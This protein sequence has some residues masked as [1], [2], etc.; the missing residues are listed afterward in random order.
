MSDKRVTLIV[1]DLHVGG[2][3]A[4]PGDD[5]VFHKG[6]FAQLLR[7]QAATPEGRSG[8][9]E[10]L[11]NGDF[12]EFAQTDTD[13]F[14]FRSDDCWCTQRESLH[15]LD[16]IVRGHEQIFA[17][18][19]DFQ[20]DGNRVTLA[21]GNHDVD[22]YWP[23]VQQRLRDAVGPRL[24]FEIG[25]D[26]VDRH[27]GLLQVGHGHMCDGAN[28][29]RNW[30]RPVVRAADGTECLEMCPGTLFMVKFVNKLEARYPFADNL[31][32]VTKLAGVLLSDDKAGF[33]AVGWMFT[34]F[35]ATSDVA[36]LGIDQTHGQRLLAGL[37][38]SRERSRYL[39]TQ[40]DRA[41]LSAAARRAEA[42]LDEAR[43]AEAMFALLGRIDDATWHALFD[44]PPV[45][46]LSL[47]SDV[48]LSAVVGANFVDGKE[49]LR[50]VA[51][52]RAIS[53]S[54]KVVVMGH[55]HQADIVPMADGSMYYNPGS[56][57]RYLELAKGQ[58]VTLDDLRREDNY[59]YA[60]NVVRV[61]P[62][63]DGL[64]SEMVCVDRGP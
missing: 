5:H 29:F 28:R 43:L 52:K 48:T 40:L 16:T 26:W 41:G 49:E 54:A 37:R 47:Q 42:G 64:R 62:H 30:P 1:S 15:K 17:A 39:V 27:D 31:L 14:V 59:P 20:R 13:A 11:V 56:W 55:T 58:R 22:L 45:P 36:K 10:L 23:A 19:R 38:N 12:L 35:V 50:K 53:R 34:R 8:D 18:L 46:T 6:Q 32:P 51:Q 4:D 9:I 61:E 7:D 25:R 33:G 63:A 21:A 60:L 2:G 3:A 57:T 44:V 24:Q